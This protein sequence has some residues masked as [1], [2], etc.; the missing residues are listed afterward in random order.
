ML[1]LHAGAAYAGEL[2]INGGFETGGFGPAW[3]HGAYRGG[4]TN[5]NLADH[6][7]A[8]DLP[9]AGSYSALLGF[10]YTTQRRNTYG[11]MSQNVALPAGL[12]SAVLYFKMR[13]QGY[14]S[15]PYDPFIMDIRNTGGGTLANVV[16]YSFTEWND[17]F[18]DSGWL[19][20]DDTIPVGY[21][22]SAWA[23]QTIQLYFEQ[24]NLFD[25][26]YETWTYVDEVSVIYRMWV[27]LAVD[28]DGDDVFGA[29]GSGAGGLGANS[30]VAG[31]TLFYQL[32]VENEGTVA[33]SYNLTTA[34]L[35]AG[36][37]ALIDPGS[38][39]QGFPYTTP[40]LPAGTSQTYTVVIV[41]DLAATGGSYDVIIDAVSAAQGTRFDSVTLRALIVD[42]FYLTD[43][44]VDGNGV[45]VIAGGGAGGYALNTAPWDSAVT[46]TV[47]VFNHGNAPTAFAIDWTSAPGL[48]TSVTY[49]ASNYT[50]PFTTVVIPDGGSAVLTLNVTG[51]SPLQGGDYGTIVNAVTVNDPGKFDSILAELR[52]RAPRVDMII[53]TSGDGLYDPTL[54]GL[55]GTSSNA[56]ERNA[57]VT[58]P[59]I[60]QNEGPLPDSYALDWVSPGAGWAAVI[61]IAGTDYAFPVTTPVIAPFSQVQYL[62]KV[63][64]P[65][66]ASFGTFQSFLNSVSQV[67]ARIAESVTAVISVADPSEIDM[68]IDGDGFNVYGPVGTGLGGSSTHPA[69]PGDTVVFDV[70]IQNILGTNSFEVS[71]STSPGW[72]VT[73]DGQS[74]PISGLPAGIYQLVAI[75]PP[76]SLGGTFDIILDAHKTD[77]PFFMDSVTGRVD[78]TPP[79][80]VDGII[81]GN[82][83]G[84]FGA[85][86]T[87]AGG[88]SLQTTAAPSVLNFTVELRNDGPTADSYQVSWNTIPLWTATL[89]G[90]ASPFTTASII[91]GGSRV[92]TFT[93]TAPAGAAVGSYGYVVDVV[94]TSNPSSVESMTASVDILG[95]PRADLIVDGNGAGVFGVLNSG[96]GGTSVRSSAPGGTYNS[97]LRVQNAG[98]FPDS[99]RVQW[100]LPAGWPPASIS[101]DDGSV[102]HTAP[103]WT[104]VLAGGAFVDLDVIVQVPA[105]I[106]GS[107]TAIFN[108][109]SSRPPN[110]PES[111]SLITTT[112]A[113]IRGYVFDDA[114]HDG[115]RGAG[116]G[117]LPGVS[118]VEVSTGLTA[119]TQASGAYSL[120]VP[121]GTSATIVEVNP[122]GFIST[123][124]D[125]LGPFA[126]AAGDTITAEYGDV[127]P[128]YLSPGVVAN[129]LAGS[130]VDFPHRVE[131]GTAGQVVLSTSNGAGATTMLYLDVDGNGIFNGTDRPLTPADLLMDPVSNPSVAILLRVF[132]PAALASGVTFQVTLDAVQSI[133]GTPLTSATSATDAVLVIGS[134]LGNLS[135]QKTSDR[136]DAAPGDVITY[137]ITFLNTGSD[138]LQNV[139]L[140]DPVSAFVAI[141][142]DGFGAGQ[143]LEWIPDGGAPV[144]LT[145][146]NADADE[147]EYS[148][149]ERMLRLFLSKN[150]PYYVAPGGTG[151][152][153]YRVRVQ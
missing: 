45:G 120:L 147:C 110:S 22:V 72:T 69:S 59:L 86:G 148:P 153:R 1:A 91:S 88:S 10:K 62:L 40:V 116:E 33:D 94:S 133:S 90:A 92:Y 9:Y 66:G 105:G 135:L 27:D 11:W 149:A 39:L 55:G 83:L 123:S 127:P 68:A 141:E 131:A 58:F 99:F 25:A 78:V 47:E 101:V 138:S 136:P 112:N 24:S 36:W 74:S 118:V 50:V 103:F 121:A 82:G 28:G 98:S 146:N 106:T 54:N 80:I 109:W 97:V 30:G 84:I 81:D 71:W 125:T 104:V 61:E 151:I 56:G 76:T 34:S 100:N 134:S 14:D 2:I 128:V 143:D 107:H 12:S 18:K 130:Y 37:T 19:D 53:V 48:V 42:A 113:V 114:D 6:I 95:P 60:I 5:P 144:Y 38:G 63:T 152:M 17:K 77:K 122:S 26:L 3:Q 16:N 13:M 102:V 85:P 52:L 46:Y 96:Q 115:T 111:A 73:F 23:G 108:S 49:N 145:F 142:P 93:V 21:D 89:D 75:V 126:L 87:G 139:V 140:I 20:D 129:G 65:G 67:D 41:S 4:N 119:I 150:S 29:P 57:T 44:V 124:P 32:T 64:I 79:A 132:V 7:V 35:P 137:E 8:A 43:A 70:E 117:G 31:D 51:P 15:S